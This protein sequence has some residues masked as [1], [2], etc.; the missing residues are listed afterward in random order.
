MMEDRRPNFCYFCS[1]ECYVSAES[2]QRE[3]SISSCSFYGQLADYY[4]HVFSLIH[5]VDEFSFK[6]MRTW[7]QSKIS[8]CCLCVWCKSKEM[9]GRGSPRFTNGEELLRRPTQTSYRKLL[10]RFA[11]RIL[12]NINDGVPLWKY[13]ERP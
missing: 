4:S 7:S 11:F 6:E 2:L 13:V 5:P 10:D 8:S 1:L 9:W 12:S 3:G